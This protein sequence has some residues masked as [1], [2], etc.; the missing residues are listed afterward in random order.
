MGIAGRK[1]SNWSGGVVCAPREIVA[2]KDD[3]GLATAV[4][5][6]TAPIRVP[7]AGHSFTPLNATEGTLID[8]SAFQGLRSLDPDRNIAALGA[9]T[10]LWAIGPLLHPHGRALKN[11]GD[12]DRQTLAGVVGTGTHGTGVTLGSLSSEVAGF[13]LLTANGEILPC[14]PTENGEIFAAGRT[15]MG[16]LGVMIEI[17][18]NVRPAYKLVERNFLLPIQELWEKLAGFVRDNRHFEFFWFP[19]SDVAICKT[20]NETSEEAPEPRSAEAMRLRGELGGGDARTFTLIN[21][22][23]P[24][25][26]FALPAAH[27]MFSGSMSGATKVRW[28]HEIFPSPRTV[29]FNEMEYAIPFEK[30]PDTIRML[31]SEIRKR[32]INTGFPIEYRTVAADDI[33]LS[34]FYQRKTATIAVHQY[35]RVNT[36]RLFDMCESIFRS[37]EGRPHWGK[38]HTRTADELVDIY[39]KFNEF[40]ALREKLDPDGK[41]LNPHLR[42]IFG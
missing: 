28:S 6:G 30:G 23:L 34:P 3:L 33:W 27:R 41:F 9:A 36:S 16:S 17:S 2:P 4:R 31:V 1:W 10:N 22:L 5:Q 25:A 19:Y 7:G 35:F 39:P 40:R 13:R 21:E 14:T 26:P 38:R 29:R 18:M 32:R 37:V 15:S 8:L 11:M 20:L 24:Y 12:I 42:S